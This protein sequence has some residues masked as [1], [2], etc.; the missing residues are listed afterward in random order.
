MHFKTRYLLAP[1]QE[2]DQ[3]IFNMLKNNK[4]LLA[5]QHFTFGLGLNIKTK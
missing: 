3:I 4:N 1:L 2:S 5:L